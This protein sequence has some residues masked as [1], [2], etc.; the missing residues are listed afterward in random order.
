MYRLRIRLS[1]ISLWTWCIFTAVSHPIPVPPPAWSTIAFAL[2]VTGLWRLIMTGVGGTLRPR[3]CKP[4][5]VD[6]L[7]VT[8][9]RR[10]GGKVELGGTLA[11]RICSHLGYQCCSGSWHGSKVGLCWWTLQVN[12]ARCSKCNCE[13]GRWMFTAQCWTRR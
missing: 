2:G 13:Q 9:H 4:P 5:G 8:G 3:A 7:R 6:M 10:C 1:L 11:C 12:L